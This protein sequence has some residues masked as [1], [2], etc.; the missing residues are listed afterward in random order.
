M[1]LTVKVS[2][3]RL[4][5]THTCHHHIALMFKLNMP[6]FS[7]LRFRVC[8]FGQSSSLQLLDLQGQLGGIT[9]NFNDIYAPFTT[10]FYVLWQV[11]AIKFCRLH[12]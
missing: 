11:V 4:L 10:F 7:T 1:S 12:S 6:I 9:I 5:K 2:H 8:I 3:R